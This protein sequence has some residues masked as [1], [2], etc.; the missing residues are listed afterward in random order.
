MYAIQPETK[1]KPENQNKKPSQ[2]KNYNGTYSDVTHVHEVIT[3]LNKEDNE[4]ISQSTK[5]PRVFFQKKKNETVKIN[6]DVI[7]NEMKNINYD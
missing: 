7:I 1:G 2:L 6:N 3:K 4:A 5:L